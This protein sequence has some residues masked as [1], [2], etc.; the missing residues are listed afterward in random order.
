MAKTKLRLADLARADDPRN[1]PAY[2]ISEAAHYLSIS[3]GTLRAWAAGTKH[4]SRAGTR[5]SARPVLQLPTAT[6]LL[7]SFF[8]LVEAHML[9][10]LRSVHGL[11]L[12][13]LRVALEN[14]GQRLGCERPL[15]HESLKTS[16][17][18]LLLESLGGIVQAADAPSVQRELTVHLARIEWEEGWAARLYP[19]T[20]HNAADAP[21]SIVIDPRFAFGRPILRVSRVP[22]AVI[23]SRY[24]GGESIDDLTADY[25]CTRLEIEEAVRCELALKAAA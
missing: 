18:P 23:A 17:V 19:L 21:H 14:V 20:R 6:A 24:K 13:R 16:G 7:L 22:T 4:R 9:R 8:N 11:D 3:P 10:S 5:R 1:V 25:G 15:I 2:S 12:Q